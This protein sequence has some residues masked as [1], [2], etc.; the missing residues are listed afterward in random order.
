MTK[1]GL[2]LT[3]LAFDVREEVARVAKNAGYVQGPT[4]YY[5]TIG[6]RVYLNKASPAG[7]QAFT[8]VADAAKIW[9]AV[10]DTTNIAALDD[11]IRHFGD[12]PVYGPL[13]RARREE[14]AAGW[15]RRLFDGRPVRPFA[16][17]KATPQRGRAFQKVSPVDC[18]R[19]SP[20]APAFNRIDVADAR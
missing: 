9:E 20:V 14:L 17:A 4:Y 19:F 7:G 3:A 12:A 18:R 10:K 2:D 5:G 16:H 11:F 13:A 6:G 1:P 15:R 8:T